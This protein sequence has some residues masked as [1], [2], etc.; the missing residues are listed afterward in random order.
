MNPIKTYSGEERDVRPIGLFDSGLGG[1]TVL[2]EL[3]KALPNEAFVYLGDTA[4]TPYGSKS[5][6]T[7]QR[8]SRECARFLASCEIKLL[9]VACN[10]ASSLALE[11]L[12]EEMDC[13]VIGTVEPAVRAALA[14]TTV[15]KIGVIGTDAT[16]AS[17][18]YRFALEAARPGVEI[19]VK[20]CPLFVPL[21][22]QGMFEGEIVDKI[23]ELYL[24]P[25]RDAGI[26]SLVLGC[27][28]YPL[29]S[30][31]IS[32]YMGPSVRIIECSKAIA[33]DVLSLL[34]ES[35]AAPSETPSEHYFV[36]DE[37]GR[38][39]HLAALFLGRSSLEAIRIETLG[40]AS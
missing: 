29:L 39:N 27:T 24:A 7:I 38:F 35:G 1:L 33:E 13:P 17:G 34:E 20:P 23:V 6:A 9:V 22:E 11:T 10:T 25:M 15:G 40:D 2:K 16:I 37:A 30:S 3:R 26:D 18:A 32:K 19:F 14:H 28:H 31:A 36:T 12:K 5:K 21:V 4:R 8:Y